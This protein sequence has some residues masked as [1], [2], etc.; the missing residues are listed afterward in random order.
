M[1]FPED[2]KS[3]AEE[4][5]HKVKCLNN[6]NQVGI[7]ISNN[8]LYFDFVDFEPHLNK[9]QTVDVLEWILINEFPTIRI[10]INKEFL[11]ECRADNYFG[12]GL[13]MQEAIVKCAVE[14]VMDDSLE[15]RPLN[16]E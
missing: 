2:L 14:M 11:C 6:Y 16:C 9:I 12:E 15:K 1:I 4:M 7:Y 5:G 10:N 8:K 13:T 3:L